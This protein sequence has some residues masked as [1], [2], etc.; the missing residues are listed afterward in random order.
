MNNKLNKRIEIF[1]NNIPWVS[2]MGMV[3]TVEENSIGFM[4]TDRDKGFSVTDRQI[5]EIQGIIHGIQWW[6]ARER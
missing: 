3:V 2:G 5:N 1:V 6:E 4:G